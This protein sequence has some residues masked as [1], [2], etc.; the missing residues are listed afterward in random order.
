MC[1]RLGIKPA[2]LWFTGW[3]SV[4]WAT[5]ARTDKKIF[6]KSAQD[7]NIYLTN[8][9]AQMANKHMKRCSTLY[10]SRTCQLKRQATT[11][12][13]LKWLKSRT[14]T[15]PNAGEDKEQQALFIHCWWECKMVQPLWKAVSYKTKMFL[16][17]DLEI[18][19]FAIYDKMKI[20]IHLKTCV[21]IF[22]LPLFII[23]KLGSNGVILSRWVVS[24]LWYIQTVKYYSALKNNELPSHEKTWRNH[25]YILCEKLMNRVHR[26]ENTNDS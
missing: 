5:P 2:T 14:L 25:E 6:F 17:Y 22:I 19:L 16:S 7:L 13:L 1:P 12:H 8:E 4:H 3:H 26:Q 18:T 21:W 20:Y 10:V 23:A 9:G 15:T 11:I 24:E